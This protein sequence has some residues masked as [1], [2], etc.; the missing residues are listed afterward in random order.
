[1][2][3]PIAVDPVDLR[4]IRIAFLNHKLVEQQALQA[5]QQTKAAVDA[6]F[7]GAGLDP[8]KAYE[9]DLIANTATA[10]VA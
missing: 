6:A 10:V 5:M 9:F 2:S 7:Q 4:N 3:D 8:A 1:M